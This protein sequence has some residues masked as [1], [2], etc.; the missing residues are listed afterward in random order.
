M[1]YNFLCAIFK[2]CACVRPSIHMGDK[3]YGFIAKCTCL[4]VWDSLKITPLFSNLFCKIIAIFFCLKCGGFFTTTV[5]VLRVCS[6]TFLFRKIGC[7]SL[8]YCLGYGIFLVLFSGNPKLTHHH[9][10]HNNIANTITFR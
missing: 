4:Q 9:T 6:Y 5:S 10:S 8:I 3:L 1:H 2:Q 7:M